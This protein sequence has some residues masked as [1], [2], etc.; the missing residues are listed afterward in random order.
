MGEQAESLVVGRELTVGEFKE[1]TCR[2]FDVDEEE[3]EFMFGGQVFMNSMTL[4][5][6][7]EKL[8]MEPPLMVKIKPLFRPLFPTNTPTLMGLN[9]L[10]HSIISES[11]KSSKNLE[12]SAESDNFESFGS[13]RV[14]KKH[15]VNYDLQK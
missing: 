1:P 5:Q 9:Q 12:K 7:L 11:E 4:E 10:A 3:V 15:S 13:L 14:E 6:V 8:E 2:M